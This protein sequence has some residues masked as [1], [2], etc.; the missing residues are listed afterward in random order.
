MLAM[1]LSREARFMTRS[2]T[3]SFWPRCINI[4]DKQIARGEVTAFIEWTVIFVLSYVP[5][6]FKICMQQSNNYEEQI[7]LKMAYI[8]LRISKGKRAHKLYLKLNY[9]KM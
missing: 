2:H 3:T 6:Y 8:L 5:I 7:S 1:K 9:T 4:G